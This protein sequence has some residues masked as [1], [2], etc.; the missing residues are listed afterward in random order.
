M[1]G[2]IAIAE[3][4]DGA[5]VILGANTLI[6]GTTDAILFRKPDGSVENDIPPA[7]VTVAVHGGGAQTATPLNAGWGGWQLPIRLTTPGPHTI[8]A[9]ARW[10]AP[11]TT[12]Q[13]KIVLNVVAAPIDVVEPTAPVGTI[14]FNLGATAQHPAGVTAV[15]ARVDGLGWV[16]LSQAGGL[17][18]GRLRLSSD[19]VPAG[20]RD[21]ALDIEA[22]SGDGTIHASGKILRAVDAAVPVVVGFTP[23]DG[24]KIPGTV[25]GGTVEVV[26]TVRDSGPGQLRSGVTLVR[27]DVDGTPVNATRIA[28]GEP[29]TWSAQVFIPGADDHVITVRAVGESPGQTSAPL[30]HRVVVVRPV[31]LPDLTRPT[32]LSDLLTFT[33]QRVLTRPPEGGVQPPSITTGHLSEALSQDLE[34]VTGS[35]LA[36]VS[37]PVKTLR[38][39]VE[40][41]GRYMRPILAPVAAWPLHDGQGSIAADVA[42]GLCDGDIEGASWMPGENPAVLRFDPAVAARVRVTP[43]EATQVRVSNQITIA[44]RIRPSAP[45]AN[46]GIIMNKEGEYGVAR[47]PDGTIRWAL[48]NTSPGW[49]WVDTKVVAPEGQWSHVVVAYDGTRV[50]TWLDGVSRHEEPAA[51]PIG[52]VTPGS[53]ELWIGGRS[54][55]PQYFAGDISDVAVFDRA[56]S[57]YDVHRLLGLSHDDSGSKAWVDDDLPADATMLVNADV[58]EWV[59]ADPVSSSGTRC[60]RS[61]AAAGMHQHYFSMTATSWPVDRGDALITDVW[62]DPANPPR[63]IMLQWFDQDGSWEHRAYWGED[64]NHWG[65]PDTQSRRRIGD[66]PPLGRWITLSVPARLVGLEHATVQGVAYTL[67]DGRAAWDHTGRVTGPAATAS[68]SGYLEAAYAAL[69]RAHGTSE[70]EL[71]LARAGSPAQRTALAQRLGITLSQPSGSQADELNRLLLDSGELAPGVLEDLFGFTDPLSARA[72]DLITPARL[73]RWRL[74]SLRDRWRKADHGDATS[75]GLSPVID[76]EVLIPDDLQDGFGLAAGILTVRLT[77]RDTQLRNLRDLR[78]AAP[79]DAAAVATALGTVLAG[80]DLNAIA[81]ERRAGRDITGALTAAGLTLR[82]LVR[83][84]RLRD[85]AA[86]GPLRNDEWEDLV[87]ELVHV[88]RVR[89]WPGWRQL[90]QTQDVVVDPAVFQNSTMIATTLLPA[91]IDIAARQNWA[92]RL[93]A[94]ETAVASVTAAQAAALGTADE[95][96]LPVL[97]DALVATLDPGLGAVEATD[98]LTSAMF[99]DVGAGPQDVTSRVDQAVESLQTF[100]LAARANRLSPQGPWPPARPHAVWKLKDTPAYPRAQFDDEWRW[101]G[102]YAAWQ[103]AVSVFFRPELLLLPTLRPGAT[104]PF[105]DLIKTL[106]EQ[107]GDL[108][109][110]TAREAAS[111]YK[112]TLDATQKTTLAPIFELILSDQLGA[113]QLSELAQKEPQVL[114]AFVTL[115]DVPRWMLEVLWLVPLQLAVVLSRAGQYQAAPD[116]LR[117]LYAYDQVAGQRIVFHG[118]RLEAQAGSQLTRPQNWLRGEELNP[119]RIAEGR[120]GAQLR[121]LLLLLSRCFVESADAEFTVDTPESRPR[122]RE[123]YLAAARSLRMPE[124]DEPQGLGAQ[125]IPPS[126]LLEVLRGRVSVNLSKLRRGLTIAGVPRPTSESD[127]TTQR[128]VLP[129]GDGLPTPPARPPLPTPYRY[130]TLVGRAQQLLALASQVESSYLAAL[131]EADAEDYTEQRANDDL[132]VAGA[133]VGLQQSAAAIAEAEVATARLQLARA[134]NNL[135]VLSGWIADGESQWEKNLLASYAQIAAMKKLVSFANAAVGLSQATAAADT[136]GKAALSVVALAT[137]GGALANIE[138]AAAEQRSQEASLRASFE[139]REQ[140]WALQQTL[141]RHDA[142]IAGQNVTL[143]RARADLAADE[144]TM[145]MTAQRHAQSAVAYLAGRRLTGEMYAWMAGE[146][147][148]VYRYL[149]RQATSVAHLAEQQLAFERQQPPPAIIQASYWT[150]GTSGDGRAAPDRRGITGSARLLRDLTELDQYAFETNR[151]KLNLEHVFPLSLIAPEAFANFRRTGVLPFATPMEAFDRRFPG[152]LLR[153]IRRVRLSIV[154]L[155]APHQGIAATLTCSGQSRVVISASGAFQ[156]LTLNRPPEAVAYTS[157]SNMTGTFDLDPQPELKYWFEDHGADTTWEF[158]LPRAA[159]PID[160]RSIAEI[161]VTVEYTALYDADYARIVKATLPQRARGTFA[162][163]L[164]HDVPDAWYTLLQFDPT[165]PAAIVPVTIPISRSDFPRNQENMRLEGISLL[166]LRSEPR[167]EEDAE[168]AVSHLHLVRGDRRLRG[169]AANAV[170]DVVSTRLGSGSAWNALLDPPELVAPDN[171][172]PATP[173]D[174]SPT[175]DWELALSQDAAT[176][177]L[178][179]SGRIEDIALVLSYRAELPPWP[180]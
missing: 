44:A 12:R 25:V 19:V 108:T 128:L 101:M 88:L 171:G 43:Q 109:P 23:S 13:D 78:L 118:F 178:L 54:T 137:A 42:G 170:A 21:A 51:G 91:Y 86:T 56:L 167:E 106:R 2:L 93:A 131:A 160:Y 79:N 147:A 76:P 64:L 115:S 30:S 124:F 127:G 169:G 11:V 102:V 46:G 175:G 73:S 7:S 49:N 103:A 138:L 100:V 83:V 6:R 32:Y 35:A 27:V 75:S 24:A 149:L 125:R 66:L 41:L 111:T 87:V 161:Y 136:T 150:V 94:R 134:G 89:N 122:A 57:T 70:V 97:R 105:Q 165:D 48:A 65:T 132:E 151:R 139:R 96:S 53:D 5:A 16:V 154:A 180:A 119:H 152:H 62:L 36:S 176:R 60:H 20:G 158:R 110:Q 98:A 114:K 39:V 159:N 107:G 18:T 141:A 71:R 26:A 10:T 68:S 74:A 14:E 121:Y 156:T 174:K 166:V 163:S 45:T 133:R 99:I 117:T 145:A 40:A 179:R 17:W 123:L 112:G 29:S 140:E 164:R 8:I 172:G 3:P 155:V 61:S 52:D 31:D 142:A 77:W 38:L 9:V 47:F 92:D 146:L 15:R 34:A 120:A 129:T 144:V 22:T 55:Q 168:L 85:L 162:L 33:T 153:T 148:E 81:A 50:R 177:D 69:L 126:P 116:W 173:W 143:S 135:D 84:L 104:K 37:A 4:A 90:E 72:S 1:G 157:P 113:A 58:W 95:A 67:F 59:S 63:E 82:G 28:G 130:P 80:L